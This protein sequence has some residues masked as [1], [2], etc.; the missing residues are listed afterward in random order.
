MERFPFPRESVGSWRKDE[1][2]WMSL[3]LVDGRKDIRPQNLCA[4]N[5]QPFPCRCPFSCLR[6]TWWI[7]VK[8]N[9]SR[10]RVS[11]IIPLAVQL[12]TKARFPLPELTAQ[13]DGW[14]VS[15][16]HQHGP[17]WR[18]H[19]ST[20]RV[21]GPSTRPFN[22]ASGNRALKLHARN[23]DDPQLIYCIY[24]NGP[25]THQLLIIWIEEFN[26]LVKKQ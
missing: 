17:C 15:I 26:Q 6:R 5:L 24:Q 25:W 22:S 14:P 1:F 21:D 4:N 11:N 7:G 12:K 10:V 3:A 19:F 9:V 18:A 20:R 8:H 16:T 2:Q 13:V 23:D